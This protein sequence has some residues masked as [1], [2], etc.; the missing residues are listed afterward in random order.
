MPRYRWS[1]GISGN[2]N[3]RTPCKP[4][5]V[6]AVI[7]AE[8]LLVHAVHVAALAIDR[9]SPSRWRNT[10]TRAVT[11]RPS[12]VRLSNGCGGSFERLFLRG[13]RRQRG[14]VGSTCVI[15]TANMR[16]CHHQFRSV[17]AGDEITLGP[18][19]RWPFSI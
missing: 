1:K 3:G 9:A 11:R 6:L 5:N 2:P 7:V 8:K 13:Y 12:R 18:R 15:A 14:N 17:L 10:L 16:H 4:A 19:L